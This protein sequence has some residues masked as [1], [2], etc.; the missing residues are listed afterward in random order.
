VLSELRQGKANPSAS[1]QAWAATVPFGAQFISAISVLELE[2][3]V[4]RLERRDA[5]QGRALRQ[6]LTTV[7]A[8][9]HGRVLAVDEA[10]APRCALLHVPNQKPE[11][12]ALLAATALTHACTM[13][14]RNER[15]F[16]V[17]GLKVLNPWIGR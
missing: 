14:T 12:D 11:R 6:W 5:K 1:V 17:A 8:A 3:G 15:D 2:I 9:F 10:V 16:E 4:L 7:L 13:V